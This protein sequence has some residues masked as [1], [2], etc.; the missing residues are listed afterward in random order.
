MP[1]Q[2]I[3]EIKKALSRQKRAAGL[4]AAGIS[5]PVVMLTTAVASV[6]LSQSIQMQDLLII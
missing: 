2:I 5:A 1:V 3:E 4:V 6:A